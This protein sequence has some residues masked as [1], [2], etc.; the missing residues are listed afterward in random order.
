MSAFL[1]VDHLIF[2][3][4]YTGSTWRDFTAGVVS[5]SI[6]LREFTGQHTIQ[7]V[8]FDELMDPSQSDLSKV[9]KDGDKIRVFA[10]NA[11]GVSRKMAT[12]RVRGQVKVELD[13]TRPPGRQSRLTFSARGTGISGVGGVGAS[14]AVGADDVEELSNII[15]AAPFEIGGDGF[16]SGITAPTGSFTESAVVNEASELDLIALSRDSNPGT[17][18]FEDPDGTIQIFDSKTQRTGAATWTIGPENYSKIDQRFDSSHVI[19][20]LTIRYVEKVKTGAGH[21]KKVEHDHTFKDDASVAKYG[22][23]KKTVTVHKKVDWSDYADKVFEANADPDVV[24]LSVTIP[25][26]AVEELL[27]GYADGA[28]VGNKVTIVAPDG[29]TSYSCRVSR[30]S[31]QITSRLWLVQVFLRNQDVIQRPRTKSAAVD[32]EVGNNPDGTILTAHLD[33]EAV[34]TSKIADEAVDEDKIADGSVTNPK[35]GTD[36]TDAI[37]AAQATAD[38]KNE[39]TYSTSDPSGTPA[40]GDIWFKRSGTLIIG[41]WVGRAGAWDPV[42]IDGI[43]IANIDAG[44]I[45]T[46]TLSAIDI[47]GSKIK[48]GATGQRVEIGTTTFTASVGMFSGATNE[49][50]GAKI[51]ASDFLGTSRLA[52]GGPINV[53]GGT[54]AVLYL[55]TDTVGTT[56]AALDADDVT[57]LGSLT[58]NGDLEVDGDLVNLGGQLDLEFTDGTLRTA[59]GSNIAAKIATAFASAT[60]ASVALLG[61]GDV[62][63]GVQSYNSTSPGSGNTQNLHAKAIHSWANGVFMED[64]SGGGTTGASI[65]NGGRVVR[66]TSSRR[67]K[68]SIRDL[69]LET[70]RSIVNGFRARTFKRKKPDRKTPADVRTYAGAIAEELAT[71]DGAEPFIVRD[72]KGRP[73]GIHYGELAAAV[74]LPVLSDHDRRVLE[75][76]REV[77]RLRSQLDL[78]INL[79]K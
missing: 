62:V 38:G 50:S 48:T 36:V 2:E 14:S 22:P 20:V 18:V 75:L 63:I 68:H 24:P 4:N 19:N 54:A 58:V 59:S 21:T 10:E 49:K 27:P 32:T 60:G 15:T 17:V 39:V 29:V 72:A 1:P 42:T 44:H 76:E 67:Y 7:L 77:E 69:E 8:V 9:V 11:A 47:V 13:L 46:G 73:D 40:D 3:H 28:Y 53:I 5:A 78:Q 71:I 35:L 79:G 70:A 65:G 33:E 55:W 61:N 31:H 34:T 16:G 25:I 12:F 66:T 74:S 41:Q 64:L 43:V 56:F 23:K 26:R 30:I 6:T 57:I 45:T 37:D 52:I 51:I